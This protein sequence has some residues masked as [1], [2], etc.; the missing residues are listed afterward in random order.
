MITQMASGWPTWM[1]LMPT[2]YE[3]VWRV[4]SISLTR[5]LILSEV[6]SFGVRCRLL[7]WRI[8]LGVEMTFSLDMRAFLY[9]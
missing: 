5:V 9:L 1:A 7:V 2:P 4:S 8:S 3:S 6:I